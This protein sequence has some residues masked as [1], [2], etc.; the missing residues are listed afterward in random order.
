MPRFAANLSFLFTEKP[1]LARF[2][3]ARE[4][5]F[6]YVEYMFPYAYA[7]EE[8][9]ALL[10]EHGLKQVLFNLP[11]GDW[12]AGERGI[13]CLPGREEAFRA[14]VEQALAYA[15]ALGVRQLNC[16]AGAL[17]ADQDPGEAHAVLVANLRYAA[18]RLASAGLTLLL[19]PV[20]P[21][22]VPGF[23]VSSPAHAL[24][25][26]EEVAAPNLK[27]QYD[28]YHAQR[29]QGR[30]TETL[31][32]H[33]ARI[34]HVQI[35]DVPGRHQPNTGEI[36]YAFLLAEL[37]R[38]GYQGYV[39]LEYLPLGETAQSLSWLRELGYTLEA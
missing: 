26:L 8:L 13:A 20:N 18:S 38:L 9:A 27:L 33:L 30:L 11:A 37:D 35:A 3:A 34:G 2:A 28:L 17:P 7:Q 29:S 21:Y 25:L 6:R 32:A 31:R 10:T 16:L 4:A 23:F 36:R 1:F 24:R 14:G 12:E 5:G 39:G 15:R 22:D 19:E